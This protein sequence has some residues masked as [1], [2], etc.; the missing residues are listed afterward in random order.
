MAERQCHAVALTNV[1]M[2]DL[3]S[4]E[5]M[6]VMTDVMQLRTWPHAK[7]CTLLQAVRWL[8]A[9]TEAKWRNCRNISLEK[10]CSSLPACSYTRVLLKG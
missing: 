5:F 3:S 7:V 1:D 6:A 2:P 9:P 4:A 10:A 8:F